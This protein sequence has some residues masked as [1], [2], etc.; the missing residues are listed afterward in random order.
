MVGELSVAV[1]GS[2]RT[3]LSPNYVG[4]I[5]TMMRTS[6]TSL[7]TSAITRPT[8]PSNALYSRLR[9][10]STKILQPTM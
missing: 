2:A 4:Y 7:N 3:T 8:K 10:T 9:T 5:D 1:S 6:H